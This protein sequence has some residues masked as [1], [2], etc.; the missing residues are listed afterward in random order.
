[1]EAYSIDLRQRVLDAWLAGEAT[2]AELAKR[3]RVSPRWISELVRR[4]RQGQSI[5]PKPR[6]GNRQPA[7][8]AHARAKLV[9]KLKQHPGMTLEQLRDWAQRELGIECSFMAVDRAL[10]KEDQT[11]KKKR[12]RRPSRSAKT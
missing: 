1:M 8:D 11:F 3:Y 10:R 2:Q 7:F 9:A 5:A 6:G 12:S 4:H